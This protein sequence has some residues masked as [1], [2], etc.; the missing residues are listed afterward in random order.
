MRLS[1]TVNH[2]L[3]QISE[4]VSSCHVFVLLRDGH[5]V[6][7]ILVLLIGKGWREKQEGVRRTGLEIPLACEVLCRIKEIVNCHNQAKIIPATP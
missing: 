1:W 7:S 3:F 4:G 6:S 2:R 5:P